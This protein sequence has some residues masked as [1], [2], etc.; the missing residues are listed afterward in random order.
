MKLAVV[1]AIA[2]VLCACKS[3]GG[4]GVGGPSA[5]QSPSYTGTGA[6]LGDTSPRPTG[7]AS[8]PIACKSDADCPRRPCGPCKPGQIV[9]REP[10]AVACT[11]NPCTN[12]RS[13]CNP[14]HLC[15]V[16]P[17]TKNI[18]D[19]HAEECLK[20]L[21]DKWGLLCKGKDGSALTACENTIDAATARDDNAACKAARA[22]VLDDHLA[23]EKPS[24]FAVVSSDRVR[25]LNRLHLRGKIFKNKYVTHVS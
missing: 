22:S 3:N 12:S 10:G 9:M 1:V 21:R 7:N 25:Y 2:S 18:D 6:S 24:G 19:V 16:H 5:S 11:R 17:D 20:L 13:V 4:S 15:V 14:Q 23:V 8:E